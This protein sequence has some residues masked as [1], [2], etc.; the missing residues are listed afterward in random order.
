MKKQKTQ[1]KDNT[2]VY[3]MNYLDKLAAINTGTTLEPN[4]QTELF[5]NNYQWNTNNK[6]EKNNSKL[7]DLDGNHNQ[8][9]NVDLKEEENLIN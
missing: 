8:S 1:K 7:F 9:K 6:L 2:I 5:L 4:N 3:A